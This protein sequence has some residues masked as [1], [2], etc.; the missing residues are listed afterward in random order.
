MRR[1]SGRSVIN[2]WVIG[3][4][5]IRTAHRAVHHALRRTR[6]HYHSIAV[7][8]LAP[9]IVCVST[10]AGLAPWLTSTTPPMVQAPAYFPQ[11]LATM[12]VQPAPAPV[13]GGIFISDATGFLFSE[14]TLPANL[15]EIPPELMTTLAIDNA[16]SA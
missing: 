8:V 5:V 15:L 7:K 11:S 9:A 13:D 14:I 2:C 4:K 3:R 10:G 1:H 16:P 6:H 12:P